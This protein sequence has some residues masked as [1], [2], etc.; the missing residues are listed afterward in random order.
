[1]GLVGLDPGADHLQGHQPVGFEL[2]G[3]VDDAHA[4]LAKDA[5]HL[6][7]GNVRQRG[8]PATGCNHGSGRRCLRAGDFTHEAPSFSLQGLQNTPG[9]RAAARPATPTGWPGAGSRDGIGDVPSSLSP[10]GPLSCR[11]ALPVV[12]ASSPAQNGCGQTEPH[13]TGTAAVTPTEKPCSH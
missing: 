5:Q 8:R 7:T 10:A 2:P 11:L 12:E 4:T 9:A 13:S 3:L 6:V 1:F